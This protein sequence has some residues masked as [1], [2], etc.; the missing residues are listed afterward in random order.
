MA[1]RRVADRVLKPTLLHPAAPR[2]DRRRL[3]SASSAAAPTIPADAGAP[4]VEQEP[5]PPKIITS[6]HS[7]PWQGTSSSSDGVDADC[8]GAV[9]DG[10]GTT[11]TTGT[12]GSG[13]GGGRVVGCGRVPKRA[14]DVRRSTSTRGGRGRLRAAAPAILQLAIITLKR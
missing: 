4:E 6:P 8:D 14:N 5:P 3:P 7:V 2:G 11:G 13:T 12:T 9:E 10:S 1:D